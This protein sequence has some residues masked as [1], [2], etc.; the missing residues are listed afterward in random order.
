[1]TAADALESDDV[2]A[3]HAFIAHSLGV[4]RPGVTDALHILEE[5]QAVAAR[6]SYVTIL[7]RAKLRAAAGR[8]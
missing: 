6:R 4:R 2:P 3:T 5:M 1:L 8:F 7:R